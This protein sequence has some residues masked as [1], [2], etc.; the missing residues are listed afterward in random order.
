[1]RIVTFNAQ[2]ARTRSGAVD[3][4]A[5][6]D[7]CAGLGADVLALQEVDVGL[8]RSGG[9]DQAAT[10]ARRTGL[11]PVFGAARRMGLRGRYGNG[12]LVRGT[13]SSSR[14]L[15]LPRDGRHESRSA[16]VATV[17]VGATPLSVAA[18]HL[19]SAG[20]GEAVRQL[21]AVLDAV[22]ALPPPRLVL[23]DLNLRPDV[24]EPVFERRGFSVADTDSPTYPAWEPAL[25]I[26]HV[27]V[28]GLE[29]GA[30]EVLDEAP[31]SDH[32]PLRVVLR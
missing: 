11:M 20:R 19:S 23:G 29:V 18:T 15:T 13:V 17:V 27:A 25:R 3:S 4:D 31:V 16:I 7:H 14:T 30:V 12:L 5:L 21:D 26:D 6:A 10:V 2:H 22:L 32:R 24:A 8:R 9:V 1:M 28:D